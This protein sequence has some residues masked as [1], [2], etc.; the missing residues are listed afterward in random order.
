MTDTNNEF[1]CKRYEIDIFDN[2]VIVLEK[3]RRILIDTGAP[4]SISGGDEFEIFDR[5]FA[6]KDKYHGADIQQLSEFVGCH[7][8]ALIGNNVLTNY[9]FQIDFKNKLFS[10]WDSFPENEINQEEYVDAD[11]RGIP[12][13]YV[14][15]NKDYPITS[16]LDT[17]AK[18]S[19]INSKY[20]KDLIQIDQKKDFFPSFGEFD[21]PMYSLPFTFNGIEIPFNFGVLPDP[22]ESAMLSAN[23]KAIIG[24]DIFQY[25]TLTFHY[26]SE[27]IFIRTTY[28]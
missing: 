22:L 26:K 16:W 11:F 24:A 3:D 13:M 8:D 21:V 25:F 28:G 12:S 19:Y 10:V 1:N 6:T 15:L 5:T 4:V 9:V 20:V 14:I 17:G 18:I 2:H 23:V 7:L 27:K